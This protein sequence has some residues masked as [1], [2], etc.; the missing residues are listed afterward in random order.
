MIELKIIAK[1]I[2]ISS[3]KATVLGLLNTDDESTTVLPNDRNYS[4]T[5]HKTGIFSNSAVR[6]SNLTQTF[7]V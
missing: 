5:S 4:P 2:N 7:L 3:C 1:E 6:N